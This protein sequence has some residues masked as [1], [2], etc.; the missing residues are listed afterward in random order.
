[1]PEKKKKVVL[2]RE[3]PDDAEILAHLKEQ[4]SSTTVLSVIEGLTECVKQ[5]ELAYRR[6]W[7]LDEDKPQAAD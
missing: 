5:N 4:G 2:L 1:M 7:H 6:K 3:R